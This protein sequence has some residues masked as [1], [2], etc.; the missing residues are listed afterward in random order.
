MVEIFIPIKPQPKDRP[1]LSRSG[2]AYTT[3]KT[4]DYEEALVFFLRSKYKNE[5]LAGPLSV[6]AFFFIERPKT[7]KRLYPTSRPDGDNYLKALLDAGNEILWKDDSQII[8]MRAIKLYASSEPGIRLQVTQLDE[9]VQS[10]NQTAQL[11]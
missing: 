8:D 1:R 5:P 6:K 9:V 10:E 11:N 2:Y 3:K 4:R 7:V